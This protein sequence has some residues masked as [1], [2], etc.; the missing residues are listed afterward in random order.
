MFCKMLSAYCYQTL[1]QGRYIRY[2]VLRPGKEAD[3]LLCGLELCRLEELPAYDAISYT[4]GDSKHTSRVSISG[5]HVGI[6]ANLDKVLRRVRLTQK[7]RL[8]WADQ[9][10]IDQGNLVERGHQVGLMAEIDTRADTVLIW[11]GGEKEAGLHVKSL[12]QEVNERI[13][14]QLARCGSWNHLLPANAE[15]KLIRDQRW[16]LLDKVFAS[17][18][19]TRVWVSRAYTQ[20]SHKL[21]VDFSLRALGNSGSGMGKDP[22]VLFGDD[23]FD[24]TSLM[25][26]QQ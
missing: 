17:L 1:P 16:T 2:M 6:T 12:L 20:P 4:W 9:I 7:T 3:P 21:S 23:E 11:L 13:S 22:Q 18:W 10:C 5:Q 26:I 19:F 15:D 14:E 8:V 24:W 25:Q